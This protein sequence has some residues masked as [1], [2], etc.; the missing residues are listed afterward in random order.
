MGNLSTAL[1]GL[2]LLQQSNGQAGQN[3]HTQAQASMPQAQD[4]TNGWMHNGS[5]GD[6]MFYQNGNGNHPNGWTDHRSAASLL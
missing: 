6:M 2:N 1:N 4:H 5:A 3:Q